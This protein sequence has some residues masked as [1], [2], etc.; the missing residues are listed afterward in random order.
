MAAP[1]G[2]PDEQRD[3]LKVYRA[4]LEGI[5]YRGLRQACRAYLTG[6]KG[7]GR[8]MPKAGELRQAAADATRQLEEEVGKI[9]RVVN[10]KIAPPVDSRRQARVME[11]ADE[12]ARALRN[13]PDPLFK[14][15]PYRLPTMK[16]AEDNLRRLAADIPKITLSSAALKTFGIVE[17]KQEDAA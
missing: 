8:W 14:G 2:S 3:V 17:K 15:E 5:S 10:A 11:L 12:T 9:Y 7:D 4:V 13:L 1:D 16:E 6:S